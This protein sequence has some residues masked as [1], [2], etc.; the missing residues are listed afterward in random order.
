[1]TTIFNAGIFIN[2][3][4]GRQAESMAVDKPVQK[5][6]T[7]SEKRA[8]LL[9]NKETAEQL[10][11][12]VKVQQGKLAE[13]QKTQEQEFLKAVEYLYSAQIL[14]EKEK[15][16]KAAEELLKAANEADEKRKRD[17]DDKEKEAEA[18][19]MAGYMEAMQKFMAAQQAASIPPPASTSTQFAQVPVTTSVSGK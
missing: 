12:L 7:L 13:F 17:A 15:K 18:K 3:G 5:E 6:L 1:M 4:N 8:E 16:R 9:R 2:S 10:E 14:E 19:K 11:N